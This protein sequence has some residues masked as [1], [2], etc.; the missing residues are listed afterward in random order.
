MNA[1]AP[2]LIETRL[3]AAIVQNETIVAEVVKKTPLGRY[4]QPDEIAGGAL[5]LASD[6]AAFM[7]GQVLVIDG[8]MT[9]C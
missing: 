4:G 8:G 1:I 3:S 7:T 5:F 2:G 6:A 9:A